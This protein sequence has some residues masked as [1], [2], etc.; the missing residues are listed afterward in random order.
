VVDLAAGEGIWLEVAREALGSE[1]ELVGV[2]LDREVAP[3]CE[4]ALRALGGPSRV[5]VGDGSEVALE[6]G[7]DVVVG[8]PP[9]RSPRL[10]SA[11]FDALA[12]VDWSALRRRYPGA[13]A[14]TD[15]SAYFFARG[16]SLL[17]EGGVLAMVMPASFLSAEGADWVR[18]MVEREG[19]LCALAPL[20]RGTFTASVWPVL[21]VVRREA[22]GGPVAWTEGL[23]EA[24]LVQLPE[25]GTL[26]EVARVTA[27]FREEYYALTK[28]VRSGREV[29]GLPVVTV[30]SITR[31]GWRPGTARIGGRRILEPVVPTEAL[32]TLP[33]SLVRLFV[34]KVLVAPQKPVILPV[35]DEDGSLVPMTPI[36]SVVRGE[37]ISVAA[38]AAVLAAPVASARIDRA[39]AGAALSPGRLLVSAAALRRLPLPADQD[40]WAKAARALEEGAPL[41]EVAR[42]MLGAYEIAR[43]PAERLMAWWEA[44]VALAR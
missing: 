30:G 4:A 18:A 2:E 6:D 43:E 7:C 15:L 27:G 3:R 39:R 34:P 22:T 25:A 12:P 37:G 40:A 42:R 44:R 9:F 23:S 1:A 17:R 24:P 36:V 16:F 33:R 10:R 28:I 35:R 41:S 11:R 21:V 29:E 31:D 5:I 26:E 8:N 38:L 14:T 32:G 20:P 19:R 13:N